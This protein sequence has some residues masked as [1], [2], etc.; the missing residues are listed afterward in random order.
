MQ[1][2]RASIAVGGRSTRQPIDK[3]ARLRVQLNTHRYVFAR[4]ARLSILH[5]N[6]GP[7]NAP[8]I[9]GNVHCPMVV[10]Y[11]HTH[12]LA[13]TS[14]TSQPPETGNKSSGIP[15]KS[16]DAAVNVNNKCP[17]TVDFGTRRETDV[18]RNNKQV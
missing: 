15:S 3:F 14:C 5:D 9:T 17:R 2:H 11:V 10:V 1:A 13:E 8:T 7:A 6:H 16:D 4:D 12:E 18:Y